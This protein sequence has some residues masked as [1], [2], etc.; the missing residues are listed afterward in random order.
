MAAKPV[1]Q[2]ALDY[3]RENFM[4]MSDKELSFALSVSVDTIE[5]YRRKQNL[6]RPSKRSPEYFRKIGAM[7]QAY[8]IEQ[9]TLKDLAKRFGMSEQMASNHISKIMPR[10]ITDESKFI[11]LP[12]KINRPE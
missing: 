7:Y 11:T 8:V 3:V 5:N 12:S 6:H 9:P 10:R 2:W 4:T 1:K